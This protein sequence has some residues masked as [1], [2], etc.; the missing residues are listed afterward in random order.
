M[1]CAALPE[2]LLTVAVVAPV[3][4]KSAV[5]TFCTASLKVTRN[6]TL[7]ALVCSSCALVPSWRSTESTLGAESAMVMVNVSRSELP[8]LSAT[9]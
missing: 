4:A 8:A 9:A 3:T 5:P 1:Y 7:S 6:V 2:A